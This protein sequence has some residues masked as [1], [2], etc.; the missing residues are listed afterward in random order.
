MQVLNAISG[1]SLL[2]SALQVVRLRILGL[3]CTVCSVPADVQHAALGTAQIVSRLHIQV[4]VF[5]HNIF[6]EV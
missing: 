6:L 5:T 2:I 3:G 1:P 4:T